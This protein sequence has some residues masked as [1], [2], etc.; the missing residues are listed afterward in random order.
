MKF[1]TTGKLWDHQ[2]QAADIAKSRAHEGLGLALFFEMGTGKTRTQIEILKDN[3]NDHG[4]ILPTIIFCPI[5]VV[6]NWKAEIAKYSDIPTERVLC[7]TGPSIERQAQFW[8]YKKKYGSEF[9]VVTNYESLNM[10][11]VYSDL[12]KFEAEILICDESHR[13]KA[14]T[15]KRT[16]AAIK[17]AKKIKLTYLLTGTPVLNSPM[18][19]FSQFLIMDKGLTFGEKFFLFRAKYFINENWDKPY[20]SFPNWQIKPGAIEDINALVAKHSVRVKKEECLDLPPLVRQTLFVEME[21]EQARCYRQMEKDFITYINDKACVA[22]L[23]LTKA[24]RL[25]QIVSG[26]LVLEDKSVK[27]FENNRIKALEDLLL[28]LTPTHKVI[29]WAV[30]KENYKAIREIC[31]KNKIKYVECHGETKEKDKLTV[32]DK[33]N[34]DQGTKVFI[35]HPISGGVGLNLTSSDISIYYSRDFSLE[36][37]LQSESR[38]HRGGS[39]IHQKITRYDLTCQGTIDELILQKLANKEVL[40]EALISQLRQKLA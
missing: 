28:D 2:K 38:N 21:S 35:G 25:Q 37:D 27:H 8:D 36:A 26:F 33:F 22:Q 4:K 6:G 23:A 12:L 29:I 30:F 34:S 32:A 20:L 24:L 19:L 39:N 18:D 31:E 5:V 3:Y 16:K 7:L 1:T 17:L 14:S 13:L 40:G 10:Y 11:G 9:I 15:A